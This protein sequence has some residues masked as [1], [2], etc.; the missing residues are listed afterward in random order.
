MITD[1]G[2]VTAM[3]VRSHNSVTLRR[4]ATSLAILL[5]LA[6][7]WSSAARAADP[8]TCMAR[9]FEGVIFTVCPYS[10]K[11]DEL[12]LAWLGADVAP[13]ASFD[14]LKRSL[15]PDASRVR[16]AMNAGMYDSDHSPH[17]LYVEGGK[18]RSPV[19]TGFGLGNFY[20][21]PNGVFS[22]DTDGGAH[23][24]TTESYLARHAAPE[25][26]TQSGPML[27]IDGG[28]HPQIQPNGP[29]ELIRNGVGERDGQTVFFVISQSPVSFGRFARFFRDGL[30]C[31]NALFLDGTISSLW[32]PALGRQDSTYQLGPMVVVLARR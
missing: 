16:F 17:G 24:E 22:V 14:A 13:L 1:D 10:P 19:R 28:L 32:A 11:T 30:H 18:T 29:S 7:A 21:K 12:R 31:P 23:V 20:L 8:P 27:V 26:A 2:W 4:L 6:T 9:P 5:A 25:W 3:S 15:G